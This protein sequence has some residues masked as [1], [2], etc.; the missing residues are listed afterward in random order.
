MK[1]VSTRRLGL[2]LVLGLFCSKFS[3]FVRFSLEL[4]SYNIMTCLLEVARKGVLF[5]K[6]GEF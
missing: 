5:F 1:S 3:L 6:E 4:P 2:H